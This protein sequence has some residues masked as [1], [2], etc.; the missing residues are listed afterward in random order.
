MVHSR[1][2][3]IHHL[4]AVHSPSQGPTRPEHAGARLIVLT[5]TVPTMLS[6][7][8]VIICHYN[9]NYD[10]YGCCRKYLFIYNHG[11]LENT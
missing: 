5:L 7:S 11:Q 9:E 4:L 8:R 6:E 2:L 10:R 1:E 3:G